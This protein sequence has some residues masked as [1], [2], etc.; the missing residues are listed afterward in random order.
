METLSTTRTGLQKK[1]NVHLYTG[2]HIHAVTRCTWGTYH[3]YHIPF[4]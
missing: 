1:G 3:L 2:K 4:L